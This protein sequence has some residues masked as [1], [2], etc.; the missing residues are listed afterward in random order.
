[1]KKVILTLSILYFFFNSS[2]GQSIGIGTTTPD[3][4]ALLDI[5]STSKG[6]LLPRMTVAQKALITAP[7]AGLLIY[8]TDGSKGLYLYNGIA[9]AAADASG[10]FVDLSNAQTVNGNKTFTSDIMA[11]GVRIGLGGGSAA[12]S[13]AV[14]FAVLNVNSSGDANTGV[15]YQSLFSN[16][17]GSAN[18]ALGFS[19][20]NLN[21][22][23]SD[24]V[25]LGRASMFK[26]LSGNASTAVGSFSMY[27]TT[28]GFGNVAVGVRSLY[29]NVSGNSCIAIGDSALYNNTADWNIALGSKAL[30]SNTD[31]YYNTATGLNSLYANTSGGKNTATGFVALAGNI[32]G[33][34]NTATGAYSM[35]LNKTGSQNTAAGFS[36][37]NSLTSG[38]FNTANGYYALYWDTSGF[39]NTATGTYSLFSNLSG[40]N[41]TGN[42]FNALLSNTTGIYNTAVGA[43]ALGTNEQGS[44]NT[45]IGTF[46]DVKISNLNNATAIGFR[47]QVGCSNCMVLGSAA[48]LN[49][50]TNSVNVGIGTVLPAAPLHIKQTSE[51][52]PVNGGGLRFERKINNNH[53]DMGCDSG[54]D[55]NFTLNGATK[56]YIDNVNGVYINT[57]DFRLKKDI[58]LIGTVMPGIMQL[59]AK[60]Y[61][62]KDNAAGAKFSYG[63]IAQ[64]VEKVFPDFVTHKGEDDIRGIGYQ[65]FSVIAIKAIQELQA[66]VD[67]LK[68]ALEEIKNKK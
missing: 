62:Y 34:E 24:N 39:Q 37:L 49:G 57:S 4:S 11:N 13:T 26:N 14:G 5:S 52:Y 9:W 54:D 33:S 25:A 58:G 65:N 45:S 16:T 2:M 56:G 68:T 17:S 23:G 27:S 60:T 48:G 12:T 51:T 50:A 10:N 8:Q 30:F 61:H 6:L 41:N 63:F 19:A 44:M 47:A 20:M 21:T 22:V 32:S 36:T 46:S 35:Y 3:V 40:Y 42:G 43:D 53:W 64:E 7:K 31:G 38:S 15:G 67:L 55:L 29:K 18:T 66:E 59:Q 1:M 28:G